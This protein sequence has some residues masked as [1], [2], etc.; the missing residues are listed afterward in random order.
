[1]N[2]EALQYTVLRVKKPLQGYTGGEVETL[3]KG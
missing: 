1:M 3:L 2:V